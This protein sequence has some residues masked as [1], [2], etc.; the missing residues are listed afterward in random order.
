MMKGLKFAVVSAIF[1]FP[2][3]YP[4]SA[5][6]WTSLTYQEAVWMCNMG[7]RQAC[8][9]M[10]AYEMARSGRSGGGPADRWVSP[11]ELRQPGLRGVRPGPLSTYDFIR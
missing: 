3:T 1:L 9:I 11:E 10:Y 8:D 7:Y 5:L 4:R 2:L 6:S